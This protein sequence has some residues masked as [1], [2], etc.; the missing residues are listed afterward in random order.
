LSLV[1]LQCI[2]AASD[3]LLLSLPP[4]LRTC[5]HYA[6]KVIHQPGGYLYFYINGEGVLLFKA[7]QDSSR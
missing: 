7:L 3:I 6:T 5:R 1:P 2:A 4:L